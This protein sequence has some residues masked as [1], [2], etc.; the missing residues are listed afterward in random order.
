MA[1]AATLEMRGT[2]DVSRVQRA[3]AQHTLLLLT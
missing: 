1:I 2:A 3:I